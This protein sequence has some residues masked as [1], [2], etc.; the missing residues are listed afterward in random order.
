[1][2]A[3]TQDRK[4][5]ELVTAR[6]L[7]WHHPVD[8]GSTIRKGVIVCLDSS[9]NLVEGAATSTFVTAGVS[10][11]AKDN[12]TGSNGDLTCKVGEGI[13]GPFASA[14]GGDAIAADDVGKACFV[15]DNQTLALTSNAGARPFG[16][17]IRKVDSLGVY[18]QVGLDL[19]RAVTAA[20]AADIGAL[21][22]TALAGTANTTLEALPDPTDTPASADALRD[23]IVA[24]LLPPLRNNIA[25]VA[26]QVNAIRTALRN[27]GLMA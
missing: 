19:S 9:G 21:T 1:M 8:G 22:L 23:D 2:T 17:I 10:L 7:H 3:T 26:T 15:E 24:T 20:Q 6:E 13:Y 11:E 25:D 27:A 14:G 12:A 4:T 16:G 5:R 18:V